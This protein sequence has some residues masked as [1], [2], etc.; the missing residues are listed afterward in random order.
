MA[1]L[2]DTIEKIKPSV[3]GIGTLQKTR[4]PPAKL[5]GTGFSV[6]DGR[7]IVTNS[8]VI[9]EELNYDNNE[10]LAVFIGTGENSIIR[11]ATLIK[12]D[13]EH[14]LAILV[15]DFTLPAMQL[16]TEENIREGNRY[17]FTGFPIGA[18]LGLYPVTHRGIISSIS[19]VVIPVSSTNSL[20]AYMIRRL[21]NPYNV[22][23]LDATAYPG[24]SGSPLYDAKTGEIIGVINKVFVKE[25]KENVLEKP[26]G[27]TYAIPVK[28]VKKLLK[29]INFKH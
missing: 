28:H 23:Q 6:V 29:Q 16:S 14:D 24:N 17:A 5:L 9:P 18:V 10:T 3:V 8:H 27:I 1:S 7:H 22:Y 25:T 13:R 4:R 26:S 15:I 12:R 21:K 11:E 19:P 2:A 20:D